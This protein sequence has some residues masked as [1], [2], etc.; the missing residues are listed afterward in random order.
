MWCNNFRILT[1][2]SFCSQCMKLIEDISLSLTFETRREEYERPLFVCL[3]IQ[4][5]IR[6][7]IIWTD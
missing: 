7:F 1:A 4:N 6:V 2:V 3:Q 5:P